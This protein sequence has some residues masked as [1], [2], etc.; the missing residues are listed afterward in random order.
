MDFQI[1]VKPA[2][3]AC[4]LQCSYC[5]YSCNTVSY[6]KTGIAIMNEELLEQYMMQHI[7]AI[8][9]NEVMFSWHGGEPLLAGIDFYK[10]AVELQKKHLPQGFR[11]IN[12]I[13][14]NGTLLNDEWARFLSREKFLAG[15]SIDGPGELHN[16]YRKS[17]TGEGSF[18][19]VMRGYRL[20]QKYGITCE[21]LCVVHS[22]NVK[23]PLEVYRFFKNIGAKFITFLPLVERKEGTLAGVTSR[24]VPAEAFGHFLVSVFDEWAEHDIGVIQVQVFE[25]AMRPALGRGHTLCIFKEDCGRVPVVEHDGNFYACDHY[26][27]DEHLQGN[28][29]NS[30]VSALLDSAEQISFGQLKS[31]TLPNK[32]HQCEVLDMCNGECPKNRFI[33]T[34]DGE[35]GLNYLCDGYQ[36]FFNYFKPFAQAVKQLIDINKTDDDSENKEKAFRD[37]EHNGCNF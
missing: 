37:N 10:R 18:E 2:G 7:N 35:H 19:K 12:G 4:N 28:I 33:Y 22:L 31:K 17:H 21:V 3:A 11:L 34:E 24:S 8:D 32:C 5:Y 29:S 16:S 23:H 1:F 20:L 36:I 25:E 26:V 27:D 14:T 15:I 6:G 30:G 13:Q 9:G